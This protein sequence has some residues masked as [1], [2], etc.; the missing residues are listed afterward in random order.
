MYL[1]CRAGSQLVSGKR[2]KHKSQPSMCPFNPPNS[3]SYFRVPEKIA[4]YYL[5]SAHID[6]LL[7]F[8]ENPFATYQKLS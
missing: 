6:N 3:I 1:G 7:N 8:P 4:L 2:G 5:V